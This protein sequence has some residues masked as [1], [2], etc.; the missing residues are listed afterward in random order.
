MIK[1]FIFYLVLASTLT[2]ACCCPRKEISLPQQS[3]TPT[4]PLPA[5]LRAMNTLLFCATNLGLPDRVQFAINAKADVHAVDPTDRKRAM[6]KAAALAVQHNNDIEKSNKYVE[7]MNMLTKAGAHQAEDLQDFLDKEP[8]KSSYIQN[9]IKNKKL[10]QEQAEQELEDIVK[11]V[12][13]SK[14]EQKK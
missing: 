1:L 6:Y 4:T 11:K 3:T 12:R 5:Q 2:H 8:I 14:D 7:I 10:T 9:L 13:S